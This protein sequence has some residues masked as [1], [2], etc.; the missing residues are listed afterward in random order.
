MMRQSHAGQ[1]NE[2]QRGSHHSALHLHDLGT[3]LVQELAVV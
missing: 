1:R 3:Q 2:T